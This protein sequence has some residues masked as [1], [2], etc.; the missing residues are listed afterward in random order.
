MTQ[1]EIR[2]SE[3]GARKKQ[4]CIRDSVCTLTLQAVAYP[5]RIQHPA[6]PQAVG[7]VPMQHAGSFWAVEIGLIGIGNYA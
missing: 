1:E 5:S 3:S 6:H 7:S 2:L 4:M